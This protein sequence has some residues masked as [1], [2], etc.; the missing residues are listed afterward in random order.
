MKLKYAKEAI[1]DLV[2][3]RVFIEER[4][5]EAAERISCELVEGITNLLQFPK[6]GIRVENA[7][8]PEIMREIYILDYHVR[9]LVLE[10]T[11]YIL[12]IWHQKEDR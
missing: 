3:L 5:P 10:K 12:R 7:P 6:T 2:R 11:V 9:Y 8:D 1:H 4:S